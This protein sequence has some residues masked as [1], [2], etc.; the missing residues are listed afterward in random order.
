METHREGRRQGRVSTLLLGVLIGLV[1]LAPASA[2]VT[3]GQVKKTVKKLAVRQ[4]VS[5][6]TAGPV[7]APDGE[8]TVLG[9][10]CPPGTVPVGGG[11]ANISAPGTFVVVDAPTDA[12]ADG[13]GTAGWAVYLGNVSGS[14]TTLTVYVICVNAKKTNTDG[15]ARTSHEEWPE[16]GPFEAP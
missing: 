5:Y 16:P 9:A 3:K 1:A 12:T 14:D 8:L 4:P 15:F 6:R 11:Q 10:F 2:D 7:L 13:P